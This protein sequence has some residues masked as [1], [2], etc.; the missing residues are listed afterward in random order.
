MTAATLRA[1]PAIRRWSNAV[2]QFRKIMWVALISGSISGLVLFA[3]QHLTIHPI[4]QSAEIYEAR[5]EQSHAPE[6][7]APTD[8]PRNASWEPAEGWQRI[9]L[10]ALS[11]VLT[12]IGFAALLFGL[13]TLWSAPMSTMRGLRWGLAGLACF[14]LA[15]SLGLPPEPPGMMAADLQSRQLWWLAT[16]AA[17]AGGLLLL[18]ECKQGWLVRIAGLIVLVLPHVIGAPHDIQNQIVPDDL[19][20]QFQIASITT[21]AVFWLLLGTLGGY[22]SARWIKTHPAS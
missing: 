11:T 22:L 10:T 13:A 15:P 8:S 2:A 4:I 16:A 17:T 6:E 20:R 19:I 14:V 7:P 3:L 5:A 18:G 9:S 1:S 21:N 12:G